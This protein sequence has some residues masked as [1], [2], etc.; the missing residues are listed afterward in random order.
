MDS[1]NNASQNPFAPDDGN[2]ATS[3]ASD[4]DMSAINEAIAVGGDETVNIQNSFDVNDI[5]LDN[6]PTSDADLQKQLSADPNM[7]LANS[8]NP[9]DIKDI[10]AAKDPTDVPEATFVSGDV[11][12]EKEKASDDDSSDGTEM[13]AGIDAIETVADLANAAP[14]ANDETVVTRAPEPL[15]DDNIALEQAPISMPKE[16]KSKMPTYILVGL[17]VIAVAA[18]VIAVIVSLGK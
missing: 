1:N 11:I 5:E 15:P 10:A 2:G 3:F 12:D 9:I 13:L 4:F 17:G 8:N 18:V 6:T 16:K 14:S 7:S